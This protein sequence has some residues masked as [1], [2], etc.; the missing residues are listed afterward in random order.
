MM[1]WDLVAFTTFPLKLLTAELRRELVLE[2]KGL[3]GDGVRMRLMRGLGEG[4]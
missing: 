1:I 2:S 3:D 4:G